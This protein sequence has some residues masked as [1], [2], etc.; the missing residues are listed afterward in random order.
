MPTTSPTITETS[1][2]MDVE[3]QPLPYHTPTP[4]PATHQASHL[5]AE[6]EQRRNTATK[7]SQDVCMNHRG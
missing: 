2:P 5:N 3:E 6:L 4:S 1:Q 7:R